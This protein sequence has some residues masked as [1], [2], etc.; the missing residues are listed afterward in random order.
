MP[1]I[2]AVDN[3]ERMCKLIKTA[4][5]LEG[6]QVESAF[7]G[8]AALQMI[9]RSAPFDIIITDLRMDQVDGMDVLEYSRRRCPQTEVIIIT[10]F[11]TQE[12]ALDAMKRG[13]NDYLIKPFKMD[14]LSLRVQR[15]L[16][17]KELEKENIKLKA[18]RD[19]VENFPGIIGKSVKM[20]EVFKKIK[21]VSQSSAAVHIRGESG[22][23]KELVARAIHRLSPRIQQPFVVINCAALPETLLESELFGY[24]KG[25]F[26]GAEKRKPGLFELAN[27]GTLFLDEVGDLPLGLQAKLLRVLQDNEVMHLGGREAIKVDFRL[28]T[29]THRSLEQ[30]IENGTFRSDLYY[31]INIFPI[32]LPPLRHRKEDIPELVEHFLKENPQK[33]LSRPAR[34]KLMEYDFPGNV[35]ELENIITRAAIIADTVIDEQALIINELPNAS[36]AAENEFSIPDEGLNLDELEKRLIV[37]AIRKAAGNKTKAAEYLG[38]TRRRLYSMMERFGIEL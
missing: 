8:Q 30:M 13:A 1:R 21:Q 3:E 35:R 16:Y 20:R 5:E 22:T 25:A 36:A 17:Q 24:E 2:L 37:N 23:G 4:L 32:E 10:A 19:S 29:A 18:Q 34:R 6:Y 9:E 38:I 14:E 11:A 31:R 12:T 27:L 7:S 15:I 26:S 33:V 28:I